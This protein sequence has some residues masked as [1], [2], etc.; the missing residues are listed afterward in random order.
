MPQRRVIVLSAVEFEAKHIA[1]A[2][3]LVRQ[4][5]R[6][7]T[8]GPVGGFEISLFVVGIRA[9]SLP[10]LEA[11]FADYVVM[12][13]FAGALDPALKVGD[14]LIEADSDNHGMSTLH[15]VPNI[16]CT[17]AEKAAMFRQTQ[18]RAVEME[19]R[20]VRKWAAD[21][22]IPFVAIRSISDTADQHLEP[23]TFQFIDEFGSTNPR[24][25]AVALLRNPKLVV[26]LNQLRRN[27]S[28][29]ARRLAEAVQDWLLRRGATGHEVP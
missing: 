10:P 12:A 13:G 20:I 8:G 22:S 15:T 17:P 6:N 29:A 5:R 3:N 11:G 23:A 27:G 19:N 9:I 26:P 7:W 2:L 1:R 24:A 14:I 28:L 4:S 18:A 25:L 21:L 16:I